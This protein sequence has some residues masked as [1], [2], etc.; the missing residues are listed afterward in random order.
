MYFIT[1]YRKNKELLILN[2]LI[3][4]KNV[5]IKTSEIHKYEH[6]NVT[7]KER[8]NKANVFVST[9]KDFKMCLQII[10]CTIRYLLGEVGKMETGQP[11]GFLNFQI[12]YE[13][14]AL[15]V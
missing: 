3:I 4:I 7:K 8:R 1:G 13:I 9:V 6:W 5:C 15:F 11:K 10:S 2:H 14:A 12:S